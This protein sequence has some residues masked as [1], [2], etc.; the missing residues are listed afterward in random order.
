VDELHRLQAVRTS[1]WR[2]SVHG[3]ENS[4]CKS[5]RKSV[6]VFQSLNFCAVLRGLAS[7]HC[8]VTRVVRFTTSEMARA[9]AKR[10]SRTTS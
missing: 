8:C 5:I 9:G 1:C 4:G 7:G 6:V 3:W 10:R 2:R